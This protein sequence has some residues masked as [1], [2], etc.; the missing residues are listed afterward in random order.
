[1]ETIYNKKVIGNDTTEVNNMPV[2]NKILFTF[3]NED[4]S[5]EAETYEEAV[6]KLQESKKSDNK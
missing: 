4:F 1:M 2:K 6:I 3:P 5:V